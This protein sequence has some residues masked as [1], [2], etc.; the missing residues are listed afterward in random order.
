VHVFRPG[1]PPQA[2]RR[3]AR[4]ALDAVALGLALDPAEVFAVLDAD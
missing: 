3:G 2:V 1:A 4:L